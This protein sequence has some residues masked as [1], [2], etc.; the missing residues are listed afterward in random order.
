MLQG[1]LIGATAGAVVGVVVYMQA[2]N[3]DTKEALG[4]DPLVKESLTVSCSPEQV[5][6]RIRANPGA[7]KIDPA[8]TPEKI[9]LRQDP[10]LTSAGFAYML[11]ISAEGSGSRVDLS[12]APLATFVKNVPLIPWKKFKTYVETTLA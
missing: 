1:A 7:H 8:S 3:R 4:Q 11:R 5:I 2:K 12:M 10:T 6:E 9:I